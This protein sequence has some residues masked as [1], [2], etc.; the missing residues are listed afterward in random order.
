MVAEATKETAERRG[1]VTRIAVQ[2]GLG[3]ETGKDTAGS[4]GEPGRR[5]DRY[6]VLSLLS[7]AMSGSRLRL[8]AGALT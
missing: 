8:R 3:S 7:I 4:E 1:V 5:F 6:P 2:L